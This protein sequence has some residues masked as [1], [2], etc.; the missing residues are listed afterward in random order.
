[1]S[2]DLEPILALIVVA[3]VANLVVMA[4]L[5]GSPAFSRS[6]AII[7]SDEPADLRAETAMAAAAVVGAATRAPAAHARGRDEDHHD[8]EVRN[9][10]DDDQRE[11]WFDRH[12]VVSLRAGVS[13]R[14][15]T[16]AS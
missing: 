2:V 15:N 6:R 1:M 10:G 5:L 7:R 11:E 9:H 8:D 16:R 3:V 4:V 14:P 12:P 13:A